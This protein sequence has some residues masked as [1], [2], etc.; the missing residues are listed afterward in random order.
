MKS[1]TELN[2]VDVVG[3]EPTDGVEPENS[4][5]TGMQVSNKARNIG[6]DCEW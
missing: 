4:L 2:G 6:V 3:S 1:A 5:P